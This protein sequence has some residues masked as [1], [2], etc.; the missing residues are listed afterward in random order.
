MKALFIN[1][2]ERTVEEIDFDGDYKKIQEK[3][4]CRCFTC[5]EL[6]A[7]QDTLYI[8]DE[9]LINGTENFFYVEGKGYCQP[10]AGN[11]LVLGTDNEGDSTDISGTEKLNITFM[12]RLEAAVRARLGQFA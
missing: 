11:G 4:G 5:V 1:A 7:K 9:G 8:D 12:D 3:I 6:N 2:E 10:F